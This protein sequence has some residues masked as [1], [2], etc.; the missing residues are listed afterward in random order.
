MSSTFNPLAVLYCPSLRPAVHPVRLTPDAI[1]DLSLHQHPLRPRAPRPTDR[2]YPERSR[3][4]KM[5]IAAGFLHKNGVLLCS[6]TQQET[7]TAKFHGPK[8][9]IADIPYGKIVFAFAGHSDFATAA[10]QSC[11]SRLRAVSPADTVTELSNAVESEYRRL[12]FSHPCF[13]TDPNLPYWLLIGLWQKSTKSTSLWMTQEHSLHCCFEF[14][15]PVGIGTDLANV[16]VRPFLGD[17]LTEEDV[18]T[19]GAYMMA[20]VKDAVPG[21]GGVSQYVAIRNDGTASTVI[22]MPLE[23]IEKVAAAYD[24]AAHS[25]LLSMNGDDD[26]RFEAELGR[27]SDN[28]RSVRAFWGNIRRTNPEVRQYL[29]LTTADPSPQQPLQE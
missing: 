12:V 29:G 21:C 4:R 7:G 16:I 26:A 28:A 3:E 25:L 9:G 22:S 2:L 13:Q 11:V 24:K 20:R 23:E 5:T 1:W 15:R 6:D 10:I 27:F 8:V 18:M 17:D 14:F 19:L